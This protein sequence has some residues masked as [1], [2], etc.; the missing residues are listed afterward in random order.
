MKLEEENGKLFLQIDDLEQ[1]CGRPLVR[2][3][4]IPETNG[5]DTTR[6]I[7]DASNKAEVPLQPDDVIVFHRVG[8]PRN[9]STPR[10]IIVRLKSIE[11]KFR[12][13]KNLKRF[14][15]NPDTRII[16]ITKLNNR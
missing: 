5:E 13:V 7:L 14:K 2:V 12:L 1:Y 3:S 16:T 10:Q 6:M 8:C 11:V 15:E 4:G 9:R